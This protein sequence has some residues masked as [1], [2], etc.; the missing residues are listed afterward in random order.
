MAR[1]TRAYSDF[2]EGVQE[3]EILIRLAKA[4][5]R[6]AGPL[7]DAPTA[8]ALCRAAVVLLSSRIEGY[9]KDLA[10]VAVLRIDKKQPPKGLL[11]RTFLYYCSKDIIDQIRDTRDP[12]KVA[13]K[14]SGLCKRDHDIWSDSEQ[15]QDELP[16]ERI[17]RGFAT[18]RFREV[19]KFIARF[20]YDNYK[21]DLKARLR[22]DADPCINMVNHVVRQRNEIAHGNVHTT[23]TP[24]DVQSML[25]LVRMFCRATDGV[26]GDWFSNAGCP[27]R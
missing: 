26:V 21:R 20:G 25:D 16:I 17:V 22:A 7:E 19:G 6:A 4:E 8:R 27:I 10:E 11:S 1:Y 5:I 24:G 2:V 13:R 12:E 14:I 18:P 9:M 3:I 23:N 15:F